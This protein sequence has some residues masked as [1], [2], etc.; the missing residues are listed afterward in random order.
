VRRRLG[1]SRH[2]MPA[3]RMRGV[4][5]AVSCD[6]LWG[7]WEV[8]ATVCRGPSAVLSPDRH[9]QTCCHPESKRANKNSS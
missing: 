7:L 9:G 3:W 6:G 1:T 8:I 2:A 5:A 4:P